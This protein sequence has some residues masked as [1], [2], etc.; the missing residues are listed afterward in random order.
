MC[1]KPKMKWLVYGAN[2]WIG[3]QVCDTLSKSYE[4]VVIKAD[5]RVDDSQS[6]RL[7]IEA[8]Q[9]D[10][11]ICLIG[12]THGGKYTTIDYLEQPGKL[13]E[14]IRDNLFSPVSLAMICKGLNV[15]MTYLGTGC[16]FT[17]DPDEISNSS[18]Y[19][20]ESL[21]DFFGSGYSTVKGYTDRLMHQLDALNVRIR[22]PII[23]SHNPRNFITKI[24]KYDKVVNIQNS[25]TVLPN[26][27]PIMLDLAK[28]KHTGTVN[29][30]NPGTVSH[31]E[32]L[33]MYREYVD[34]TFEYT[35]FTMEEQDKILDSKRSNN[36]LNTSLLEEMYPDVPHIKESIKSLL[37]DWE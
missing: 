23:G 6:V 16:I 35:N 36:K 18:G 9:P 29:L 28:K 31:N 34:S 20:E 32:I 25:M 33:D 37:Q 14:N 1:L 3:G 2:G 19:T 4:N 21:P 10:R 11:V 24:T 8:T 30:T 7:E 22:M 17:Q 12:R 27:I 26:L 15:H 5:A 13:T